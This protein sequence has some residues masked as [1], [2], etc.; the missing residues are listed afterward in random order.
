MANRKSTVANR[1]F[2]SLKGFEC[3]GDRDKLTFANDGSLTLYIQYQSPG[4]DKE[5]NWLP[6][7]EGAFSVIMRCYSPRPEIASGEWGPP[8][9]KRRAAEDVRRVA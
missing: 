1:P 4:V 8:E 7:P 5:S 2:R 9:V 3:N 6:S